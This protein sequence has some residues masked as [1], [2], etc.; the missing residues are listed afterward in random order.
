MVHSA[1]ELPALSRDA[2]DARG[3]VP[4]E[5]SPIPLPV[6]FT[7]EQVWAMAGLVTW[8]LNEYSVAGSVELVTLIVN[9]FCA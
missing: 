4:D 2:C 3:V 1:L 9:V 6:S 8:K 7:S 5:L